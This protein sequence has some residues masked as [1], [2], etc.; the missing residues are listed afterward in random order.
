MSLEPIFLSL[1]LSL[2][3]T[4]LLLVLGLPLAW[5]LARLRWRGKAVVEALVAMPLVLPPTVMGFYLLIAF[6]PERAFGAWLRDSLGLEL[7]F[8]FPGLVVA[9]VIYSLPFMVSPLQSG[10]ES[11]P[12]GLRDAAANLGK[13]AWQTLW[14]V[15]LPNIRPQ[16]LSGI[17]LAFAHTL[18]EFGVVLMVGGNLEGQ[19]RTASIALYNKVVKMDYAASHAYALTLLGISFSILV[20]FFLVHKRGTRNF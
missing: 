11:L 4:C 1:K 3:T 12:G 15:E 7:V 2:A 20:V 19:T 14:H 5:W 16:L 6:S 9:S 18:G 8:T 13:S 10:F 17:I